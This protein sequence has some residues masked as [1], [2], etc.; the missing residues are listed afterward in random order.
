MHILVIAFDREYLPKQ[1]FEPDALPFR[2]CHVF[3]QKVPVTS[4]L[5]RYQVRNLNGIAD[6][7]KIANGFSSTNLQ[8]YQSPVL[9]V[10]IAFPAPK[11]GA[12]P[13]HTP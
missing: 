1:G 9:N 11:I 6:L 13:S 3:L 5:Y 7:A 12:G 2:R 4:F 8:H 10:R